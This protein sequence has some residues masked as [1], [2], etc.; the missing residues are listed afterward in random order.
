MLNYLQHH[1]TRLD[2]HHPKDKR[3]R[4]HHETALQYG[5]PVGIGLHDV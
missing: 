5:A 4:G 3:H 1:E 2:A